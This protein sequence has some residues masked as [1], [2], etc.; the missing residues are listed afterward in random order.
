MARFARERPVRSEIRVPDRWT[1]VT[2]GG[3][4]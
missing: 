3:W 2:A 1:E 4:E